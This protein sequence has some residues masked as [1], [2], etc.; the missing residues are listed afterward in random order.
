M[1]TTTRL[2]PAGEGV[3]GIVNKII[4]HGILTG[5]RVCHLQVTSK[6]VNAF[7]VKN[8]VRST[9]GMV[10]EKFIWRSVVSRLKIDV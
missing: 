4:E 8:S 3:I 6:W 10:A 7:Y 2:V 9:K 5:V 1:S